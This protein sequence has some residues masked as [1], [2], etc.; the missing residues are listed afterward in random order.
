[1][2]LFNSTWVERDGLALRL[3]P[4]PERN[5]GYTALSD[6]SSPSSSSSSSSSLPSSQYAGKQQLLEALEISPVTTRM[7]AVVEAKVLGALGVV[8]ETILDWKVTGFAKEHAAR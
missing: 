5:S 8:H 3:S 6:S 2:K 7:G 4:Q 1:M